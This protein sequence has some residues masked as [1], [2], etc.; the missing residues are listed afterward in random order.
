MSFDP[1]QF[2]NMQVTEATSTEFVSVPEGDYTAV[3]TK[4]DFRTVQAKNG[5]GEMAFMDVT[6]EI[7][8][9]TGSVEAVTGRKKNSARQ[10]IILDVTE[11]GSLDMG[12]GRNVGLGRLREAVG[13]NR[14]GVAWSPSMLIGQPARVSIKHRMDGDRTFVDVRSVAKL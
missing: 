6:W 9:P 2:M 10:S 12:K 5:E 3:V 13:Q 11:W 7:D 4:V 1:Q 14:P 8:D